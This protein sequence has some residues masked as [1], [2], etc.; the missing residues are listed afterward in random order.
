MSFK[1]THPVLP[2]LKLG[3][4]R[5]ILSASPYV[6]ALASGCLAAAD[7]R[8]AGGWDCQQGKNGEWQCVAGKGKSPEPAKPAPERTAKEPSPEEEAPKAVKAA[9][10]SGTEPT[11]K[12]AEP[13]A[14]PERKPE[15]GPVRQARPV[16]EAEEPVRKTEQAP[17]PE[18]E[19]PLRQLSAEELEKAEAQHLAALKK[20]EE[21]TAD[22][23]DRPVSAQAPEAPGKPGWNC[24]AGGKD[25][26]CNLVGPDPRGLAHAVD[27]SGEG[28]GGWATAATLTTQDELRFRSMV[29]RLPFDPWSRACGWHKTEYTK[30]TDFLLSSADRDLRER[31]PIDI[32]SN[33]AEM[34]KNEIADFKG[35]ADLVRGDQRLYG[36]FVSHNTEAETITAQGNVIYQE[37]GLSFASD[38]AFLRMKQ[39]DGILRNAQFLIQ[40][41]PSRGAARVVHL[42]NKDVSRYETVTYTACPPGNQDW[43]I[44]A[45]N[46]KIDRS[47][48]RAV[49]K[50][51]WLEFKGVPFLYTP[52]MT[53]PTDDRRQTGFLTPTFGSTKVGGFDLTVPYYFNL[54]PNYDATFTPRLLTNRGVMFRSELRYLADWTSGR[55]SGEYLPHDDRAG[56][57]RG[58]FRIQNKSNFMRGLYGG[59]DINHVSDKRYLNELGNILSFPSNRHIPSYANLVHAG[60]NY[61]VE[62]RGDYYETIDTTILTQNRPYRRLPQLIGKYDEEIG[63]T[64]IRFGGRSEL[65]SFQHPKGSDPAPDPVT[66]GNTIARVTGERFNVRPTFY[67]PFHTTAGYIKPSIAFDYTQY[68]LNWPGATSEVA[69][70]SNSMSRAAPIFSVDTGAFFDREFDFR[71]S[72]MQQTLEPRLFYLYVPKVKQDQIPIFDTGVYDFNFYQLFRE[73]RFSGGDRLADSNQLSAALT[74]RLIEQETGLER[75]RA[76]IGDIFYFRDQTV[77][78]PCD[79]Q[80][81]A[82][83]SLTDYLVNQINPA[84]QSINSPSVECNNVNSLHPQPIAGRKNQSNVVGEVASQLS[85]DW[86]LRTIGQWNPD[87][88]RLD[89]GQVSLQYNN[90]AN[91]LLNLSYRYRRD[92]ITGQEVVQQT[93]T[94]FRL[95]ITDGW[96]LSGRWQYSILNQVTVETFLG[97]ERETCCWRLSIVGSR[98]L[99]G[100]FNVG[101]SANAAATNNAIFVQFELKGLTRFGDQVDQFLARSLSGFR[102]PNEVFGI[103]PYQQ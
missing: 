77:T 5:P 18:P 6:I 90:K 56:T 103:D 75:L 8:A 61:S 7:S 16:P 23:P 26:D 82:N 9:K 34:L 95:P 50:N 98:F 31:S 37:K 52:I 57:S 13:E 60:G 42:D 4:W 66:P 101:S 63:N 100:A 67:Y 21:P 25:W 1:P 29:S 83:Q 92:P 55:V 19:E 10:P 35:A 36:D 14:R 54:A 11:E 51:A 22:E 27:G 62:L 72:P 64:G 12:V 53:F 84:S 68:W 89:R 44:H 24:K 58:S 91:Q 71:S 39:N 48:G 3:H 80:L 85:Q 28:Y 59:L 33:Y 94:S 47:T 96:F 81:T 32:H 30:P 15:G 40:T 38:T 70:R 43:L 78:L 79:Q 74:T 45:S 86:S 46:T 49:A 102:G 69:G 2:L 93:D 41:V 20:K 17:P 87:E 88:G 99:N 73:N 76:S 97:I 65:V